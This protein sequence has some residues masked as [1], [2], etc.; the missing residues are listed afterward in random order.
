[1]QFDVGDVE[2]IALSAVVK[3]RAGDPTVA[4]RCT[5]QP[6]TDGEPGSAD[7][8]HTTFVKMTALE[9]GAADESE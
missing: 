5:E 7:V 6:G 8:L 9:V 3:K 1:M 4:I 2:T